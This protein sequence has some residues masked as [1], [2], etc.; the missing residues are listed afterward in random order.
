M[1]DDKLLAHVETLQ[2]QI[3]MLQIHMERHDIVDVMTIV[4]PI[5]VQRLDLLI[6]LSMYQ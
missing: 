4:V 6:A 3:C 2:A 1:K 5:N